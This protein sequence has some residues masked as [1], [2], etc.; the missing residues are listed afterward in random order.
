M[1]PSLVTLLPADAVM[2]ATARSDVTG[3]GGG[4]VTF[5]GGKGAPNRRSPIRSGMVFIP[6]VRQIKVLVSTKKLTLG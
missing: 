3:A 5:A 2:L 4:A 6:S 1:L